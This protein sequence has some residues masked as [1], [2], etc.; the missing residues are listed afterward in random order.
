VLKR[1]G[2]GVFRQTSYEHKEGV[3]TRMEHTVQLQDGHYYHKD[4]M[5]GGSFVRRKILTARGYEYL[6]SIAGL[7][8]HKPHSVLNEDG[9]EVDNPIIKRSGGS[10]EWV[11]IREVLIGRAENGNLRAIDLTLSYDVAAALSSS[12][13]DAWMEAGCPKWGEVVN[14]VE[15]LQPSRGKAY[16]GGGNWFTYS[17]GEMSVLRLLREHA[18]NAAMADRAAATIVE[19]NL[20]RRY[21]GFTEADENAIVRFYSWPVADIDWESISIEDGVEIA[22][23]RAIVESAEEVATDVAERDVSIMQQIMALTQ[24]MGMQK[25]KEVAAPVLKKHGIRWGDLGATQDQEILLAIYTELD[26]WGRGT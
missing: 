24:G 3:V 25:A 2:S 15:Y 5:Q 22:G 9:V 8:F 17:L 23:E 19:R 13:F 4:T 1:T 6:A 20:M 16:I 18:A 26:K 21:F 11:R 14:S 7:V 12:L 10:V